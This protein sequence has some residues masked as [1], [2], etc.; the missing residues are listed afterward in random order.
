MGVVAFALLMAAEIV[1]SLTVFGTSLGGYFAH[2]VT[3]PGLVG[4]AG[5]L[6][7]AAFPAVRARP[8][9]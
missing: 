1:L 3:A 7:F 6:F 8:K 4:L 5:Q 9:N 2:F